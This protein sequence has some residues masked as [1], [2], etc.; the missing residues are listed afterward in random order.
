[1][2]LS[3]NRELTIKKRRSWKTMSIMEDE[4]MVTFSSMAVKE[5]SLEAMIGDEKE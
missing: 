3:I 4:S 2:V 5:A 1:M